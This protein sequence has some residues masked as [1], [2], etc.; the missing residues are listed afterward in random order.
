MKKENTLKTLY[1]ISAT[2]KL[3]RI[4]QERPSS[5]QYAIIN[6]KLSF[7]KTIKATFRCT[8]H[9][10]ILESSHN[11][12]DVKIIIDWLNYLDK[13][14][15]TTNEGEIILFARKVFKANKELNEEITI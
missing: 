14:T 12:C 7:E 3:D 9:V 1:P 8:H 11:V 4:E 2:L 5:Q 15:E 6:V 10:I 13:K